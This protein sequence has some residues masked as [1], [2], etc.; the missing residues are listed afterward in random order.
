MVVSVLTCACVLLKCANDLISEG[1]LISLIILGV[2][3][4]S[5]GNSREL[6]VMCHCRLS[7]SLGSLC[8]GTMPN[9]LTSYLH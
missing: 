7:N 1:I 4:N 9:N 6:R 8:I 5:L 3:R 2:D